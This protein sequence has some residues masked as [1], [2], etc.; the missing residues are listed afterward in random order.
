MMRS[1]LAL[2][3]LSQRKARA[4]EIYSEHLAPLASEQ[5]NIDSETRTGAQLGLAEA[6]VTL[7]NESQRQ[8]GTQTP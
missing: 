7:F 1:T 5:V 4:Q 3:L 8:V 2:Y 6:C